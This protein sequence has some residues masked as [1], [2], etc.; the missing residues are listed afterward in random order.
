MAKGYEQVGVAITS[1]GFDEYVRMFDLSEGEL[2]AGEIVDVA[3]GGSSFT[4]DASDRGLKARA[5]DPRYAAERVPLI[6]EAAEEIEV[7]AGKLANLRDRY[8]W[9]FYGS[10]ERHR[11][12]RFQSLR[13]FATHIHSDSG[14]FCYSEG[15]LPSLPFGDDL[16]S[17]VL[18]SHFLFLYEEQFDYE[19]HLQSVLE[20]MRVC[21]P[22]GVIRIYPVMSLRF[23][24][25]THLEKLL[26]AING[27]GGET[28]LFRTKLSFIPGSEY[29]LRIMLPSHTKL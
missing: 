6:Q 29:G 14:R 4:A 18:C 23:E 20:M 13:R 25:Y 19:F 7:S 2:T 27:H 11:E 24:R 28:E 17:L 10:L 22:G 26:E 16:F 1:R 3:A 8:D 12:M 9:T 21:K 15:R 5:V